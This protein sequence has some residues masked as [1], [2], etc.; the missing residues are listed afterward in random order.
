M[1]M[2]GFVVLLLADSVL[3]MIVAPYI[4]PGLADFHTEVFGLPI[5]LNVLSFAI[6]FSLSAVQ[7]ALMKSSIKKLLYRQAGSP[8]FDNYVDMMKW[9]AAL[10]IGLFD[11]FVIDAQV[12][13]LAD[14]GTWGLVWFFF[15][16]VFSLF[17]EPLAEYIW[18]TEFAN[19]TPT[20]QPVSRPAFST[21]H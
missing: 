15:F 6:G 12:G 11:S 9:G 1:S 13:F 10:A 4:W 14:T 7:R 17:G 16:G 19:P 3:A 21:Q 5:D 20:N 2:V 8:F 18:E